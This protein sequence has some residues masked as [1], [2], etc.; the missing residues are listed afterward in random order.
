MTQT[1]PGA[2]PR[3]GVLSIDEGTTGTRSGVVLDSGAA[4]EVFYRSIRVS[5]P[6]EL[7]VEQDPME[8]WTATIEVA[9][10]A[11]GRAGEEG[12]EIAAVALSTQRATAMLWDRVTG[13]PLL[14]AVVWQDR[15][16]THE[17]TA[18]EAEWDAA[19]LARQGRPVGARSPFLWAA[20]Q[21]AAHP[22]VAAAHRA[23]RLLFGTVDTWLI[24]RLTGG[25][26]HA[27]TP[28]NAASTGGYLLERHAWDEEWIGHLGFPL[29]LLPELRSD[30]AGFGTT[31]P[32]A[33]GIAV[34]LT[35]SM[36]DQH[37]ALV[38]LGGLA[39]GQGMCVYGTG[40][41]VDAATGTTPALPRPDLTGVVAQPG[42]RQGDIS[43]YSLEAYTSTAGSALRWL[44]DDLGLFASPKELCEQ[45]GLVP[46]RPGRT[47]RF[48]P[49]L[50]GVRTPV[51][52]P[53]A[54]AALT[55][56][57]L[58][59]T[60]A[61][62]ARAVVDGIAHSVCDLIDAVAGTMGNPFARLRVGG[63]VSGGD[64]LM[65]IQADLTG[66]PL[67]R[68]T[69]SATASLRGTAYL[70]GVA[71]GLWSSLEEVVEAQPRGQI[72]EP[73][74]TEAERSAQ[75]A[76][77]REVLRAHLNDPALLPLRE[78]RTPH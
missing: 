9:R 75:R 19:L 18:Y 35:A 33:L 48:V 43:H 45:A 69:D 11:V 6:D 29:D 60:R 3:R 41:F 42:R 68:V 28:T 24:W 14:P 57:T 5:H 71:Q 32:D 53:E 37:A 64:P 52:H 38:G 22:E 62:L 8:I 39:T 34:P 1:F 44:C 20:R 16:Y 17:L 4:S 31:D 67:E 30:D 46:T 2:A 66:L 50:A 15:R 13:K 74:I 12:I 77:W 56:L 63:G 36:G 47:P 49:A 72:F 73:S 78:P 26:V 61:D 10:R 55:G 25:A 27:T 76:A 40:A 7:S 51:W 23:G 70:A 58:A 59:T 54:T 21:I 65:Q